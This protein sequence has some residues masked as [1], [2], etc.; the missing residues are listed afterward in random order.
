MKPFRGFDANLLKPLAATRLHNNAPN[1]AL[2]T[3]NVGVGKVMFLSGD[4][5]WR[6]RQVNG[7]NYHERFWGQVVRWVFH[8]EGKPIRDFR[9][10]WDKAC[11]RVGLGGLIPHDLR[12]S[13]V[14]NLVRAGV[15]EQIA[16]R[17]SG[18]KTRDIFA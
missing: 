14:R 16:M 3:M 13:A 11:E 8:R 5:T 17:L 2:A 12:R 15:P 4:A 9:G 6:F 1:G 7:Q 18:H 10:A